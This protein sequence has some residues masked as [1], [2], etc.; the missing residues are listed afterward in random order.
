M[1]DY[2]ANDEDLPEIFFRKP[3]A[4]SGDSNWRAVSQ[5]ARSTAVQLHYPE[6][7]VSKSQQRRRAAALRYEH[8]VSLQDRK[9]YVK[10]SKKLQMWSWLTNLFEAET[11]THIGEEQGPRVLSFLTQMY[12]KFY[13]YTPYKC[14]WVTAKQYEW[15][16]HIACQYLKVPK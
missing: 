2:I 14:K 5:T 6:I 12:A 11:I 10:L 8:E 7:R 9:V 1:N 16:K 3:N 13:R 4:A 15:L